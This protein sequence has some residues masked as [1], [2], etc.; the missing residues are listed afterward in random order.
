MALPPTFQAIDYDEEAPAPEHVDPP[1]P[2]AAGVATGGGGFVFSPDPVPLDGDGYALSFCAV[3]QRAEL[4]AFFE[5]YGVVVVHDVLSAQGTAAAAAEIFAAAGF[6]GAGAGGAGTGGGP[7]RTLQ[8]LERVEWESVYGSRYN[9]SKGFLGYD[10]PDTACAWGS[11]LS[12]ALHA[13]YAALFGRGD[14]LVKL[15]RF[16][17]MVDTHCCYE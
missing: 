12:P 10:A 17:M 9:M 16:G 3:S 5:R 15:D 2:N 1:Q 6:G 8:E 14:L 4:R 13:A 11:R 7:P